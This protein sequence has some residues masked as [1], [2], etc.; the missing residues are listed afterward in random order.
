ME[1]IEDLADLLR[2]QDGEK[3]NGTSD[4]ESRY[5]YMNYVPFIMISSLRHQLS[6]A[7]GHNFFAAKF[8]RGM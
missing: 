2:A 3:K 4:V 7:T 6:T 8:I 1:G 5:M